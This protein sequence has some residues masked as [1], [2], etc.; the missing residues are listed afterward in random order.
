MQKYGRTYHLPISPG[1]TADDKVMPA[2]DGLMVDDLLITEKMDG[3][4]TTIHLGGTHAR[5][6][7][8]RHHPSRDWLKAFAAG[9][10][11]RLRPDE[12]IIGENLYARHTIAYDDLPS[13]F[14]G[15]A[16]VLG[17]RFQSWDATLMR[18]QELGITPVRT[19]YRGS[20]T[21]TLFA[22]MAAALHAQRQEGFVARIADGFSEADMP[23]RMGKFVRANH[24]HSGEHWMKAQMVPNRLIQP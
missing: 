15:F 4:N 24:V 19:L 14:L 8:S 18:F 7:D 10:S 20:Y 5:S 17:D 6:P 1:A 16:L 13:F 2:V 9:I 23:V 22:D 21:A 12:R 11:P 3:E